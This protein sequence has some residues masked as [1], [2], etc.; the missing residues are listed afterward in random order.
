MVRILILI[1]VLV[2]LTPPQAF[3]GVDQE[4]LIAVAESAVGRKIGDYPFIDQD[5]RP[6]RLSELRGMPFIVSFNYTSCTTACPVI[7][8]TLAIAVKKAQKR[9]GDSFK[10]VTIGFDWERDTPERMREYGQR[11]TE[12]FSQWIFLSGDRNAIEAITREMGFYYEKTRDGFN[13]LNM[14]TIVDKEGRVYRQVYGMAVRPGDIIAPLEEIL[15]GRKSTSLLGE[16]WTSMFDTIKL[17]CSRYNPATGENEF[18]YPY[19]IVMVFQA[20]SIIGAFLLVWGKDLR[21]LISRIT[22]RLH[23]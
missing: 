8:S 18:Y 7:A 22:N 12:D 2:L 14:V 23:F 6:F 19:L 11:F 5:G 21:R 20:M 15:T 16:W 17:L 1:V 4:A 9:F 13:H 3:T 10:V